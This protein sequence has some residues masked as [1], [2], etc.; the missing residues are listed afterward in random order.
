[1]SFAL[2]RH[3]ASVDKTLP[4]DP[5]GPEEFRVNIIITLNIHLH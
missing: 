1:M 5:Q 3:A 2:E 4:V